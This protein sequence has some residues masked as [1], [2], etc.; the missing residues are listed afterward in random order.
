M[1][2]LTAFGSCRTGECLSP[3]L[4]EIESIDAPEMTLAV[5]PILRQVYNDAGDGVSDDGD[6][7]NEWSERTVVVPEPWSLRILQLR[8]EGVGRGETWLSDNGLGRPMH[9]RVVRNDFYKALDAAGIPRKQIRALRRSWRSWTAATGISREILEK[10]MGHVSEG[11]TGRHYLKVDAQLISKEICRA[12][13]GEK[14]EVGWDFLGLNRPQNS[15]L[16]AE[17]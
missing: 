9:Q 12:M 3:R 4:D 13:G 6:L 11:T 2:L 1:F 5:V 15:D 8:D 14:I 10:M 17:T 7:K 16:P